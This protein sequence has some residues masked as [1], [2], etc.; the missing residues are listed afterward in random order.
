VIAAISMVGAAL[1]ALA[2]DDLKRLLAYSTISQV[3][4]M[5][6][7]VAVTQD[8]GEGQ[9][10]PGIFHLLS[11]A[12]FKALLFLAAGG[13]I[14]LVGSTMLA[15]MGGLLR[16][17]RALAVLFGIGLAG[18]A[19]VPPLGG[20]WSKEA[21]LTAADEAAHAGA[22]TGW[23]VL[24]AGLG[25][26][27]LTGLYAGR[28]WS[29]VALGPPAG[30][31]GASSAHHL[32]PAMLLPLYVLAVPTLGF[33]L[34]LINPP[35]LLG[36]VHVDLVTGVTGAMLSLAGLGW[37]LSAPRLGAPDI[38]VA[39]PD[40]T[41]ALL[42]DGFRVDAVQQA[43]VVRP[44]LAVAQLV[45]SADRDVIDA[46]IRAVPTLAQVGGNLLRRAQTGLATA[47]AAGLVL[48]AVVIAI[49]GVMLA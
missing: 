32:P 3:A 25:T 34:V 6:A 17:H 18:L 33:G 49:A 24:L 40:G 41:R 21:V 11:H 47:Y 4:Y 10:G 37:A 19:G 31:P 38:A 23:V 26:S 30:P 22:W 2:Q 7:G 29:I 27:L 36:G 35:D 43:L 46:Y 28:A 44:V 45:K 16:T 20:F 1:A 13:V 15:D 48:G 5:L 42:R 39:I 9:L 14:H 12:A 8:A